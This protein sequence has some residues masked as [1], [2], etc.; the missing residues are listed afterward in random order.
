MG[1]GGDAD[2][3]R[4][5]TLRH[6][7]VV[8]MENRSFDHM[9]GY[10]PQEGMT[11]VDGLTGTE[12]NLDRDGD[13]RSAC[14]RSTPRPTSVQRPGE[15]LQKT[16]DPDHSP[17]GVAIQVGPGYGPEGTANGGFVRSFI[18]SRKPEDNVGEDLWSVPMGY[19]TSKDVPVYDH[20]ARQY[21]VCDALAR[22]R[23]RATR[24]R[25]ASTRC[26]GEAAASRGGR[27]SPGCSRTCRGSTG[28]AGCPLY[29]V[30]AFTR[31]LRDDQWRWYSHDPA[32]LRA[33]RRAYRNP[34]HRCATTSPSSTAARSTS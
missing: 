32:T 22:A 1:T 15:A 6:I 33:A 23:S 31:Q 14:T 12:F 17:A 29:D 27:G 25:T 26:A 24:G 8:M 34:A 9:L 11:E 7:V 16:L 19:Y 5:R 28:C 3:Q 30:P 21:C 10:L 18:E 13:A 20:L 2:A 4:L